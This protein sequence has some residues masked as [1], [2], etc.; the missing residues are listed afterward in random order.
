[1]K[2][3][4]W[5]ILF[6]IP[7]LAKAQNQQRKEALKDWNT[8]N[9][10]QYSISYPSIWRTD[11]SGAMGAD[12]FFFSPKDNDTDKLSENVN[13]MIQSLTG[14]SITLDQFVE[15]SERQVKT[16]VTDGVLVESKRMNRNGRVFHY[17]LYTGTQGIFKLKTAQY[18]F[19]EDNKVFV[20]TLVTETH[21]FE[22]Y[23][24]TGMQILDSF[25]IK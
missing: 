18:Y 2:Q 17:I 7:L 6:A 11:T 25:N 1:M 9:R 21:R 10:N 13:V 8:F 19:M 20:V 5:C 4:I 15:N 22:Q 16:L 14:A 23:E 3:L 12:A 24:Q